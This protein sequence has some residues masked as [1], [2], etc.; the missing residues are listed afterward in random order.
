MTFEKK[1][2]QNLDVRDLNY[3]STF[4]SNLSYLNLTSRLSYF[5][6]F[7]ADQICYA[8]LCVFSYVAAGMEQ[9]QQQRRQT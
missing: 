8:V 9:Q 6:S 7:Q 1:T 3:F 4:L 5:L 2:L